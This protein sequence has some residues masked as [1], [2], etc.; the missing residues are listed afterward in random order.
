MPLRGQGCRCPGGESGRF[1]LSISSLHRTDP[2][3]SF[4]VANLACSLSHPPGALAKLLPSLLGQ[5]HPLTTPP[6]LTVTGSQTQAHNS[7]KAPGEATSKQL[8]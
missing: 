6:T 7:L 8:L 5:A 3:L 2:D 4:T 1:E